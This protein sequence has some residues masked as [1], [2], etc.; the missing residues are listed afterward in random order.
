[1]LRVKDR[2]YTDSSDLNIARHAAVTG[3]RKTRGYF[4]LVVLN[5]IISSKKVKGDS[6]F[7]S[8]RFF[9]LFSFFF[10]SFLFLLSFSFSGI[11]NPVLLPS[12]EPTT[13]PHPQI[14]LFRYTW[15]VTA[16]A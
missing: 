9:L 11:P 1:M 14:D 12:L 7:L 3:S 6:F 10:S 5:L 16:V 15:S 4:A 13:I 2:N 8:F